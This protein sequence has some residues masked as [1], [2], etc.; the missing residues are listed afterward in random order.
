MQLAAERPEFAP[1]PQRGTPR[2]VL[3][4]LLAHAL[5][6]TLLTWGV[7]WRR[8]AENEAVEAE[9][10]SSTA[11]QAAPRAIEPPPTQPQPEPAPPPPPPPPAV[12]PSEPAPGPSETDIALEREKERKAQQERELE[13]QAERK[14]KAEQE[15]QAA[16]A[17]QRAEEEA[18]RKKEEQQKLAEQKRRQEAEA[19]RK[20][21]EE[22][23]ALAEREKNIE[24]T[25]R[26]AGA[27]GEGDAPQSSGPSG[28]YAGRIASAIRRNITFDPQNLSGNPEAE[29]TIR[30]APDGTIVGV[31]LTK[32][33]G[34]PSWDAA[35]ERGIRKTD[36]IPRDVDGQ[37]VASFPSILRPKD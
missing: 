36:K 31:Q 8:E 24:R 9:L 18:Q 3:L 28:S 2:A 11:Q 29:F 37:V 22:A 25:R 34:V 14:K 19:A 27:G 10:W 23:D 15:K 26:L 6:I 16:Q 1:P 33:S 5:L 12:Q 21:K 20:K 7:S 35:A 4:A 13:R 17:R 30:A 32:S